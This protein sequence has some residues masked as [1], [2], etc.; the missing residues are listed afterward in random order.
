[1]SDQTHN[2]G[3]LPSGLLVDL[4]K[5]EWEKITQRADCVTLL[6]LLEAKITS[7]EVQLLSDRDDPQWVSKAKSALK[8]TKL[9]RQRAQDHLGRL[10]RKEKKELREKQQGRFEQCFIDAAKK[11]LPLDVFMSL[12]D[13]AQTEAARLNGDVFIMKVNTEP[14]PKIDYGRQATQ[15][16]QMSHD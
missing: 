12:R 7:I 16:A 13:M 8:W 1:M 2:V 11:L 14:Y 15:L 10:S 4:N 9:S 3:E 5:P 6:E